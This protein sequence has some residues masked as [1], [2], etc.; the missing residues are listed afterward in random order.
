MGLDEVFFLKTKDNQNM[1]IT[2]NLIN[3][4]WNQKKKIEW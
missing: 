1:F 2:Y 4:L 3:K